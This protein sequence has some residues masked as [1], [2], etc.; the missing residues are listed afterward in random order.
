M[1]RLGDNL[2]RTGAIVRRRAADE[3][4]VTIVEGVV[5][6]LILVVGALA[7]LGMV[8]ASSRGAY[9]AEQS[10]VVSNRLQLEMEKIRQVAETNFNNVGLTQLPAT[11]TDPT[12]PNYRV[13]GSRFATEADGSSPA[14]LVTG[15]TILPGPTS[16]TSGDVS[17]KIYR[18]VT[19]RNDPGCPESLCPGTQDLKRV[20]IAIKPDTTASGGERAYQELQSDFGDPAAA[21]VKNALQPTPNSVTAVT[22][23]LSDTPCSAT[24]RTTLSDH[25]TRNTLGA[26]SAGAKTGATPG[27]PDRLYKG[28]A[29]A[30]RTTEY[31][32]AT[33]VEP[34]TNPSNDRG[35]QLRPQAGDCAYTPTVT[36]PH[37][38][39]HRWLT[40]P[41]SGS[42]ELV[43]DSASLSLQS[44]TLNTAT[45]PGS[46][47]AFLFT[48]EI[49]VR[50]NEI[51]QVVEDPSGKS[52][53]SYSA[54]TW[55][56]NAWTAVTVP[57]DFSNIRVAPGDRLGVALAVKGS[58]S[59][60]QLLQ[61]MYDMTSYDSRLTINT[62]T[63]SV[64]PD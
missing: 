51:D 50:G 35:L 9:R 17:G 48:R 55:P 23:S 14:T 7:V 41:V 8:D 32:Y 44:K 10:Q 3:R 24:T 13:S 12:N 16:F 47:C 43:I 56:R 20:T 11:S 63:P 33:D 59:N 45:H 25:Q 27:A 37:Q 2:A 18:Y 28:N 64:A 38:Y 57:M 46:I 31:D 52:Y 60:S 34:A 36:N 15:G 4:G 22:Y 42:S 58:G 29:P 1:T 54:A 39:V 53:F 61:F 19:W 49:G 21:P 40:A 62:T 30:S 6:A 26:C 5:A